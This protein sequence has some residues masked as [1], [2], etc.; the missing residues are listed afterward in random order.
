M[1]RI[2]YYYNTETCRY[3]PVKTT[4]IQRLLGGFTFIGLSVIFGLTMVLLYAYVF[5]SPALQLLKKENEELHFHYKLLNQ[6]LEEQISVI[7]ALQERD[8]NIYRAVFEAHP[9]KNDVK[10][11]AKTKLLADLKKS[12]LEQ[13][14]LLFKMH[15]KLLIE[16]WRRG[17]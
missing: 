14:D 15:S 17:G 4:V 11:L 16:F 5:E 7:E 10:S 12:N 6:E 9:V 3:E 1:A 13:E 2:K 8:N